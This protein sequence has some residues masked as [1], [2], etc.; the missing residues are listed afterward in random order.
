[1][2]IFK[3]KQNFLDTQVILLKDI[4]IAPGLIRRKG[5]ILEVTLAK[6]KEWI[7]REV[8][9][10]PSKVPGLNVDKYLKGIE[11]KA[12]KKKPAVEPGEMKEKS[13]QT[14]KT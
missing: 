2:K 8:A 12:R 7:S 5:T 10:D 3:S 13:S 9:Q 11:R 6:K 1:M 14:N 4:E